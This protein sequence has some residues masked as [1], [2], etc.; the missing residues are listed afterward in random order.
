VV[1]ALRER[2]TAEI[3][4]SLKEDAAH[5]RIQLKDGSLLERRVEHALGSRER[6][7]SDGD[8]EAKFRSQCAA[9]LDRPAIDALLAA[10]WALDQSAD[11]G[12][13]A[14]L[15]VPQRASAPATA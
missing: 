12:K 5:V 13:L 6:P 9:V 2:V 11:G 3:D 7:M 8:L 10:C 14:R 4:P 1:V 15:T